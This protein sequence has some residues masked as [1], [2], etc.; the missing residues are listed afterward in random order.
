MAFSQTGS[1]ARVISVEGNTQ[2]SAISATF[3]SHCV[4][5][6]IGYLPR[7]Q[8]E[9]RSVRASWMA[10]WPSRRIRERN[11]GPTNTRTTRAGKCADEWLM[12][13]TSGKTSEMTQSVAQPGWDL[14]G[15][16][17]LSEWSAAPLLDPL[18]CLG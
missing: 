16:S 1:S 12:A 10:V 15:A 11:R 7:S 4:V 2:A 8:L 5:A 17:I 6:N 18:V 13:F 3:V 9:S 14:N